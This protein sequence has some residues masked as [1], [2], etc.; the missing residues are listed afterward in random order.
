MNNIIKRLGELKDIIDGLNEKYNASRKTTQDDIEYENSIRPLFGEFSRISNNMVTGDD[1][2]VVDGLSKQAVDE[3]KYVY[4]DLLKG[5][6]GCEKDLELKR[7]GLHP[8]G[9][10]DRGIT[11]ADPTYILRGTKRAIYP[12]PIWYDYNALQMDQTI[13][14]APSDIMAKYNLDPSLANKMPVLAEEPNNGPGFLTT[15]YIDNTEDK[16]CA[17][18]SLDSNQLKKDYALDCLVISDLFFKVDKWA[19]SVGR[20]IPAKDYKKYL[21]NPV[22]YIESHLVGLLKDF[23]TGGVP[24]EETIGIY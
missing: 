2:A 14:S 10:I 6:Y 16:N 1:I 9:I 4:N 24:F 8:I 11:K 15:V 21:E 22:L 7:Q 13:P 18:Y 5:E 23:D 3:I 20:N 17:N 12:A 19:V